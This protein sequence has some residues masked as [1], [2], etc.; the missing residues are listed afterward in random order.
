MSALTLF[1]DTLVR[2]LFSEQRFTLF[3]MT[4]QRVNTGD[5]IEFKGEHN[6]DMTAE[7][8]EEGVF[9]FASVYKNGDLLDGEPSSERPLR[10]GSSDTF[11][12]LMQEK[13]SDLL[14]DEELRTVAVD[15]SLQILEISPS[16][17]FT[18]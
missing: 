1:K 16:R 18:P 2:A 9:M 11:I 4:Y 13:A 8:M 7:A 14:N 5:E 17:S 10:I 15:L 6:Q 12:S 3:D